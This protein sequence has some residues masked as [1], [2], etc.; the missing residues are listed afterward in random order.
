MSY[1]ERKVFLFC[2]KTRSLIFFIF[3]SWISTNYCLSSCH[4]ILCFI[5]LTHLQI[6]L[7]IIQ[8][9][10]AVE[11]VQSK[12]EWCYLCSIWKHQFYPPY[13][14]CKW[15]YASKN[16]RGII[17]LE[18]RFENQKWNRWWNWDSKLGPNDFLDNFLD[19]CVFD[20][21]QR[22][23]TVWF[24][25]LTIDM[26]FGLF[27]GVQSSG[28]ASY[29]LA[30]FPYFILGILLVRSL[31]LPGAMQGVIYF[32]KPNFKEMLSP[33]VSLILIYSKIWIKHKIIPSGLVCCRNSDVLLFICMLQ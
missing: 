18:G 4:Y 32:L 28:K 27:L 24:S 3:R 7:W 6:L 8:Q 19:H 17:L 10:I 20:H 5:N 9:H 12:L 26:I 1:Y 21:D 11:C 23:K 15:F 22:L 31:T 2:R 13:S 33:R 30:I 14:Q 25:F 16:I 29:V